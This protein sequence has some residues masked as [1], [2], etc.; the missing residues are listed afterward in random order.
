[1]RVIGIDP[2]TGW[3]I[4]EMRAGTQRP[5]FVDCDV[6]PDWD[7][8]PW[9]R[10]DIVLVAVEGAVFFFPSD[11]RKGTAGNTLAAKAQALWEAAKMGQRVYGAALR[12]GVAAVE[13]TSPKWRRHL[14]VRVGGRQNA[15]AAALGLRRATVD[16]EVAAALKLRVEGWPAR[17]N[18]T[19][20]DAAGVAIGGYAKWMA[21]RGQRRS[22]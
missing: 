9:W 19:V 8:I 20:R 21:E 13:I 6:A 10:D 22:G 3:A 14:G 2:P 4:L 16:V 12:S 7:Q 11:A 17:S 1:M 18:D 15:A 5:L